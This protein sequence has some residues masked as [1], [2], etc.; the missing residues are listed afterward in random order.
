[1][2]VWYLLY[3]TIIVGYLLAY[4]TWNHITNRRDHEDQAWKYWI[5]LTDWGYEILIWKMVLEFLMVSARFFSENYYTDEYS[6]QDRKP[7]L[8]ETNHF[9]NQLLW[10]MTTLSHSIAVGIT[11]A[12]WVCLYPFTGPPAPGKANFENTNVHLLQVPAEVL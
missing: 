7:F 8:H 6:R 1:M 3:K 11:F 9:G 2:S 5:Y 4:Y 10:F 12:F